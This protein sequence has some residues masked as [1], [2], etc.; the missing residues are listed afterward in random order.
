MRFVHLCAVLALA[1]I[2]V[3]C[4][5]APAIPPAT[6]FHV[7]VALDG[8]P[9]PAAYDSV[10]FE[11]T[12]RFLRVTGRTLEIF[13]AD[14][15]HYAQATDVIE[16]MPSGEVVEWSA[17]CTTQRV[18]YRR[19][20]DRLILTVLDNGSLRDDTLEVAGSTLIQ[21]MREEPSS[22]HPEGRTWRLEYREGEPDMPQIC[23]PG[24]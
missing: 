4:S 8:Q 12:N 10:H 3:A 1:P 20:G 16:R 24:D 9:I 21:W 15:A 23:S 17:S 2:L 19:V 14:S 11:N 7:L 18:P 5:E 6:S 22:F 13:S